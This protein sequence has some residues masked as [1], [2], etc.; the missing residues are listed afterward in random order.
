MTN[1]PTQLNPLRPS[2]RP[3]AVVTGATGGIGAALSRHLV[4]EGWDLVL[5]VRDTTAAEAL[6][7]DL[8]ERDDRGQIAM[9]TVDLAD[10]GARAAAAARIA[11]AHPAIHALFNVA[12]I[13]IPDARRTATGIDMNLEVNA[14][15]PI[16]LAHAFAA[17]L[18]AG[19]AAR[20]RAVVVNVS[21][22][23]I[24]LSGPLDVDR[25]TQPRKP[26]LFGA[27]GQ[28]KLALT[29]ATQAMGP[30]YGE[31]G[32]ELFA[33]DP[34]GNRTAMTS[35]QG[36]PF[37]VRWMQRLLPGPEKGAA[38]LAAPLDAA[39]AGQ[40]GAL[41]KGGKRKPIPKRADAPET[42]AALEALVRSEIGTGFAPPETARP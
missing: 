31:R 38:H 10:R 14:L 16:A 34:G 36:A 37:F 24:A 22:D 40:G 26:G 28:S 13:L 23:A 17:P 4:D 25:L 21:S 29:V 30:G 11:A 41:L 12:G 39:W 42:V 3:L 1:D 27:Y 6:R 33:V 7:R 5:A 35:G 20:G 18:S 15:A 2:G 8:L 9:E 32:I 19:A